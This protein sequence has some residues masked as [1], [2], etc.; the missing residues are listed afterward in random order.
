MYSNERRATQS[1]RIWSAA[2]RGGPF[3]LPAAL[4]RACGQP[5]HGACHALQVRKN[6]RVATVKVSVNRP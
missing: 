5:A 1:G 3:F 4:C 2:L 6:G